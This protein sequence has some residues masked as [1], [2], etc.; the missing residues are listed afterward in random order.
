ML[1]VFFFFFHGFITAA[2][3]F[4]NLNFTFSGIRGVDVRVPTEQINDWVF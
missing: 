1:R 4:K 2:A 3:H